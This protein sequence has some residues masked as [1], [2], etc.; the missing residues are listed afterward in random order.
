MTQTRTVRA[1]FITL[2]HSFDETVTDIVA[3]KT[4]AIAAIAPQ[5]SAA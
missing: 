4:A 1:R 2:A 5:S 3:E